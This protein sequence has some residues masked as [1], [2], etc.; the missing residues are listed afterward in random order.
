MS[1][2]IYLLNIKERLNNPVDEYL[3]YFSDER[4][5]KI[6]RYKFNPDRN[7]TV[8]AELLAKK[9][10]S[11]R[12]GKNINEIKIFRDMNGRPYCE[13]KEIFFSLSH[14]GEWIA[15]SIGNFCNGVDVE[16]LDRK[17]DFNIAKKFFLPNEYEKI[18]NFI[19]EDEQRKKFFEYWTLKESCLKCL[20]LRE[21]TGV[22]CEKLLSSND[23]VKGKNFYLPGAIVGICAEKGILPEKL[24]LE[25]FTANFGKNIRHC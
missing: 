14:S 20:N 6:L 18:K 5:K 11:E 13:E 15:C 24:N 2:E 16:I 17:F 8:W 21:W 7:R 10:I 9:L 3:K 19:H 1:I 22:D 25:G 23:N 12:T 4:V